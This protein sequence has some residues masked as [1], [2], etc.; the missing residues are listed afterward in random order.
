M[1]KENSLFYRVAIEANNKVNDSDDLLFFFG[2]EENA[3]E[4]YKDFLGF[5]KIANPNQMVECLMGALY[6]GWKMKE[7]Y[8][9][10]NDK[11][12]KLLECCDIIE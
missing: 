7:L 8:D 10:E 4:V 5:A 6:L 11:V 3:S 9:K 2:S 1:T 12:R